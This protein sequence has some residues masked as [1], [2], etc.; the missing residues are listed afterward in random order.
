MINCFYKSFN[1]KERNNATHFNISSKIQ[2]VN[3]P[4]KDLISEY[5]N[6]TNM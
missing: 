3:H 4:F 2:S 5:D 6:S 1:R